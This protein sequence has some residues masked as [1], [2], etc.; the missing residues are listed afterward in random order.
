MQIKVFLSLLT[1]LIVT[2]PAFCFAETQGDEARSFANVIVNH[3]HNRFD[4]SNVRAAIEL[5]SESEIQLAFRSRNLDS[6]IEN[7]FLNIH[8]IKN[9][10]RAAE[11]PIRLQVEDVL[12][13]QKIPPTDIGLSIRPKSAYLG[14]KKKIAGY[15][16]GCCYGDIVAVFDS[17]E[18]KSRT[19][20]TP[21]DSLRAS[22]YGDAKTLNDRFDEIPNFEGY[23]EAQIWGPISVTDVS[24]FLVNCFSGLAELPRV[25][26]VT[27][28]KLKSTGKGVFEC[29]HTSPESAAGEGL[30]P[31]HQY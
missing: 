29:I 8:Q 31:S 11:L 9:E 19:T 17:P 3:I 2:F 7:G 5:R 12:A 1:L 27:I 18:V 4:R 23:W 20:Y 10:S 6:V 14:F 26:P 16:Y 30:Y 28:A 25:N 24:Y 13:G 15:R 21:F 22:T